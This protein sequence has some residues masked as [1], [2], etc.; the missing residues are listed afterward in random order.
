MKVLRFSSQFFSKSSASGLNPILDPQGRASG[1]PSA[2]SKAWVA[3]G[4]N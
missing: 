2:V 3:G 4:G 1:R